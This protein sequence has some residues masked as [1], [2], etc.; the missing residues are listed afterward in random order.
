MRR[1]WSW[2]GAV[3]IG[4]LLGPG[5]VTADPDD[6]DP[7]ETE[8][9][10]PRTTGRALQGVN[11]YVWDEDPRVVEEWALALAYSPGEQRRSARWRAIAERT[12][13]LPSVSVTE[14]ELAFATRVADRCEGPGLTPLGLLL[15][16]L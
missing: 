15:C 6:D 10:W 9:H 16:L 4:L 13:A 14:H 8:R 3:V 7:V 1:P 11:F 5:P 12:A 2:L